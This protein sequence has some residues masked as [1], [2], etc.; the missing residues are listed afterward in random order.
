[1]L[2]QEAAVLAEV[3]AALVAAAEAAVLV[4][5]EEAAEAVA[6]VLAA[7]IVV[8]AGV[9]IAEIQVADHQASGSF[10]SRLVLDQAAAFSLS[11]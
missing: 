9:D 5:A 1:M 3:A 4:E 8:L 2:L 7:A 11:S 10:S 6:V